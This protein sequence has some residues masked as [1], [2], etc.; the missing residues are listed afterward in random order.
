MVCLSV[1]SRIGPSDL[2]QVGSGMD[3]LSLAHELPYM[4]LLSAVNGWGCAIQAASLI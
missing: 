3:L 4:Q 2:F 1:G